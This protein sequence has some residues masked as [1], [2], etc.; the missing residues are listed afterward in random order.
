M[1]CEINGQEV[2][3]Q[4]VTLATQPQVHKRNGAINSIVT[5]QQTSLYSTLYLHSCRQCHEKTNFQILVLYM[6]I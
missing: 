1:E 5:L 3:I 6:P 2:S 4:T